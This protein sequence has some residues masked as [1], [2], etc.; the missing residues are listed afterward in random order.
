MSTHTEGGIPVE[1]SKNNLAVKW[2]YMAEVYGFTFQFA[3]LEQVRICKKYFE[4]NIHPSTRD[5]HP[6]H[7]HYW[8]PWYGKLPKGLNKKERSQK[9]I[10][11]LDLISSKW[12]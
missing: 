11:A 12:S 5:R 9:V 2:V 10:K 3:D 8:H 7:E 4:A 1:K 6:P